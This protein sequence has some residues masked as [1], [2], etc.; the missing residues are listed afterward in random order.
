MNILAVANLVVLG[1]ASIAIV[2][3]YLHRRRKLVQTHLGRIPWRITT[4]TDTWQLDKRAMLYLCKHHIAISAYMMTQDK[5]MA[6][7]TSD[8]LHRGGV[9][10][11]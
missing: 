6:A 5:G 2:A 4:D 10:Y 11:S 1:S 8:T 7:R 9:I 3:V